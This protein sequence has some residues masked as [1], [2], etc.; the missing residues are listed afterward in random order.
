[1]GEGGEV[2]GEESEDGIGDVFGLWFFLGRDGFEFERRRVRKGS[3][4]P[5]AIRGGVVT[6]SLV[7]SS[8]NL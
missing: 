4:M 8:V 3:N 5:R 2:W 6:V 7:W 1:M